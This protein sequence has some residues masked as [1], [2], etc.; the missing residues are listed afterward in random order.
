LLANLISTGVG[1]LGWSEP[2]AT[3]APIEDEAVLY[4]SSYYFTFLGFF[5]YKIFSKFSPQPQK[6]T[7]CRPLLLFGFVAMKKVMATIVITFFFVLEKNKMTSHCTVVVFFSG[8]VTTKKAMIAVV[9]TF[10]FVFEKKK[11]TTMNYCF[12][13]WLCCNEEGCYR[14]LLLFV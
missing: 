3:N 4:A 13:L 10:F 8:F 1:F 6:Q 2:A 7:S 5:F 11:T 14:H 12:L 9:V